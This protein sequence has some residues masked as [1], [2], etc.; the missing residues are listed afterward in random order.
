MLEKFEAFYSQILDLLCVTLSAD[1]I[2]K[3][4]F[5]FMQYNFECFPWYNCQF[6]GKRRLTYLQSWVRP[7]LSRFQ[8]KKRRVLVSARITSLTFIYLFFF[9]LWW[10][11]EGWRGVLYFFLF[12]P[13]LVRCPLKNCER[14]TGTLI[15]CTSKTTYSFVSSS[16]T[17]T[18]TTER[19]HT[20]GLT[21]Q[22]I[23]TFNNI[24]TNVGTVWV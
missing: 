16:T 24:Q 2:K 20:S 3:L 15:S 7:P 12:F 6:K 18:T 14:I 9:F 21:T 1:P 11:G 5:P 13:R 17:T 8:W 19:L 4:V 23:R 10:V 22:I